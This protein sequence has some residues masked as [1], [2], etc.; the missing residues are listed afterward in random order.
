MFLWPVVLIG[1]VL[2]L[3]TRRPLSTL[4]ARRFQRMGL[5]LLGL[6]LQLLFA[7][8]VFAPMLSAPT[9]PGL[10]RLGGLL[11]V[12]SLVLLL[13]FAWLNRRCLGVAVMGLGLLMNAVVIAANGG[14]MPVDPGQLAAQGSLDKMQAEE[15]VGGW[16]P[17]TMMG[18]D[19]RLAFLADSLLVMVPRP[20][21]KSVI[22][23]PGDLVVA[24]GILLFL[25]VIPEAKATASQSS[26]RLASP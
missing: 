20:I 18:D 15:R 22:V 25:L 19:T 24:A 23:S 1:L 6:G 17:H 26:G 10:P 11:Y 9:L 2:A 14:Q 21:A 8:A 7:P 12:A 16:S 3:V 13:I 4:L 5:L